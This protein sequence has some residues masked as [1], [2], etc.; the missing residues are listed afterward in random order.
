MI[1]LF[2]LILFCLAIVG[3]GDKA[4]MITSMDPRTNI[5]RNGHFHDYPNIKIDDAYN[6]FFS[7]PKW[8][9]FKSDDGTE[10]VE[11][12]GQCQYR[13]ADVNVRQQF[14]LHADDTFEAGAL[15]I[16][17]V[18]Q[19]QLIS[20]ALI[21]TIFATYENKQLSTDFKNSTDKQ[22]KQ[23]VVK[24]I[25]NSFVILND[26]SLNLQQKNLDERQY[27]S[28]NRNIKLS[29]EKL[30]DKQTVFTVFCDEN[31]IYSSSI[32]YFREYR[33]FRVK[34]MESQCEFFV[35]NMAKESW[36]MGYDKENNKWN[37]YI[38][39]NDYENTVKGEPWISVKNEKL[40]LT[41]QQEGI[42]VKQQVYRLEWDD[43]K[44]TFNCIDEG[45]Q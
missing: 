34:D 7:S 24:V 21:S 41:Y 43:N 36:L 27:I 38:S 42:R 6:A 1:S 19:L 32:Y 14:I 31:N 40:Y 17:E 33:I 22:E 9:Y 13:N 16:N 11:F 23:K 5:I 4:N 39:S 30:T 45:I 44:G 25:E 8:K 35:L 20:S 3:C 18:P 29:V 26:D 10:V 15:S 37:I 28:S 12:S 2:C